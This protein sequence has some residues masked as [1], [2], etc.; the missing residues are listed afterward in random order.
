M[1]KTLLRAALVAATLLTIGT[2]SVSAASPST[3]VST[4]PSVTRVGWLSFLNHM[5]TYVTKA[6]SIIDDWQF[7]ADWYDDAGMASAARAGYNN[8]RTE[9]RWLKNRAPASCY[10]K[11]WNSYKLEVHYD[12]VAWT[13]FYQYHR[14]GSTSAYN[15]GMKY[16]KMET[17]QTKRTTA[18]LDKTS[19]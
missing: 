1:K 18:L 11:V 2:A 4:P 9:Y 14:T 6:S 19:C 13:N 8:A 12:D 16:L 3:V 17:A 15:R 5:T 10:A 7:Y